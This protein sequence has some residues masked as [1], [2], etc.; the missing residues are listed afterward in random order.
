MIGLLIMHNIR[1]ENYSVVKR[2]QIVSTQEF[3]FL[4]GNNLYSFDNTVIFN[5]Y[6][7]PDH[8]L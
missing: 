1:I 2:I 5:S 8:V 7:A 3:S 6:S 4:R